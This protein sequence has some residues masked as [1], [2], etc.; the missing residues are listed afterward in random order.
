MDVD[1]PEKNPWRGQWL[2]SSECRALVTERINTAQMLYQAEVS[3]RTGRLARATRV[4]TEL[5]GPKR[6]YWEGVLTVG[7]PSG[8][9]LLDYVLPH[10]FGARKRYDENR[11]DP[12]FD[13]TQGAHDLDMV[14]EL[15]ALVPM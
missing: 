13:E 12:L 2:K 1:I 10:E 5:G 15:I 9:G 6:N 3:R 4:S 8:V 7:G 14:L 11:G